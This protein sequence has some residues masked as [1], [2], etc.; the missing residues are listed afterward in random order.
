MEQNSYNQVISNWLANYSLFICDRFGLPHHRSEELL[1]EYLNI[2]A[3]N[4]S[5]QPTA[6]SNEQPTSYPEV[7]SPHQATHN[8]EQPPSSQ[9]STS[10]QTLSSSH[11]QVSTPYHQR[12]LWDR[13][14]TSHPPADLQTPPLNHSEVSNPYRET[15]GG[16]EPAHPSNFTATTI[17]NTTN[18]G[19]YPPDNPQLGRNIPGNL[20]TS[21]TGA[22]PPLPTPAV[23]QTPI[24]DIHQYDPHWVQHSEDV[25][26][27]EKFKSRMKFDTLFHAGVINVGDV[28]TFEVTVPGNGRPSKTEAHLTVSH[29]IS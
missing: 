11:S 17:P 1:Q 12:Y 4:A 21:E 13:P 7:P 28:L 19:S 6:L 27:V 24:G 14:S 25:T 18:H 3:R 9:P 5:H 16:E 10:L 22:L 15:H 8:R 23:N 26:A 20:E 2:T 29:K